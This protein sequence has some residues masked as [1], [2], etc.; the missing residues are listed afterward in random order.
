[1]QDDTEQAVTETEKVG[2]NHNRTIY[3]NIEDNSEVILRY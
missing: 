3:K 2:E 1:M